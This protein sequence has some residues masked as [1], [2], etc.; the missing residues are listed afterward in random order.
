M[1]TMDY[2][3]YEGGQPANFLDVGGTSTVDRV[4]QATR[5]INSDPDVSVILVNIF[6]GIVRCDVIIEGLTKAVQDLNMTKPIVARIMGTN[7]EIAEEM[8]KK[9]GLKLHWIQDLD[10]AVKKA[11]ALA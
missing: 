2:I 3:K 6:G 11:V 10:G 7:A 5:L 4:F 8:V 9:S 1:A